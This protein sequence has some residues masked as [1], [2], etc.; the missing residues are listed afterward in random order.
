MHTKNCPDSRKMRSGDQ[1]IEV[2]EEA[3]QALKAGR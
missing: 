3:L 2:V 1:L